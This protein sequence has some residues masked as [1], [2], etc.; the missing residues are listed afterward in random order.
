MDEQSY[1]GT[2]QTPQPASYRPPPM[3]PLSNAR[4]LSASSRRLAQ[5]SLW[6]N[7]SSSSL[8]S[9]SLGTSGSSSFRGL[10]E[11][12]LVPSLDPPSP[13]SRPSG[14]LT[15]DVSRSRARA[16]S[17]Y[18]ANS[19]QPPIAEVRVENDDDTFFECFDDDD[20]DRS[21]LQRTKRS[22]R[23]PTPQRMDAASV[24]PSVASSL[25]DESPSANATAGGTPSS[26]QL[27]RLQE[28]AL[29]AILRLKEELVKS[30]NRNTHLLQEKE[31]IA[32]DWQRKQSQW[33]MERKQLHDSLETAKASVDS[34][35]QS[36]QQEQQKDFD[37]QLRRERKESMHRKLASDN[38]IKEIQHTLA[39]TTKKLEEVTQREAQ[40]E[41]AFAMVT[42]D[43]AQV[44]QSN[45]QLEHQLEVL[46][47][48]HKNDDTVTR[49][50]QE[51]EERDQTIMNLTSSIAQNN[52]SHQEQVAQK[53]VE[54]QKWRQQYKDECEQHKADIDRFESLKSSRSPETQKMTPRNGGV[55]RFQD[56]EPLE[57]SIADRLARMRDSAERA[58]LI[59]IHKREIARLKLDHDETIQK[60]VHGHQEAIRKAQ[61]H[62]D[63][64][65]AER[66]EELKKSL[67]EEYE[68]QVQ[69]TEERQR[70]KFA[71]VRWIIIPIFMCDTLFFIL[72]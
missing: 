12:S 17:R 29:Q 42:R 13:I 8:F 41:E 52:E 70:E 27:S 48:E 54:I 4:S 5:E 49:L 71:Q 51:L 60:L 37:V 58:H 30:N 65:L 11:E 26:L 9:Y 66:L 69:E 38:R 43:K 67:K 57:S 36:A 31:Q 32:D 3:H 21:L 59:K 56:A 10:L 14:S 15:R 46:M 35:L 24:S 22:L 18:L 64:V 19:R 63:T 44:E 34:Q 33:E 39:V 16:S 68:E 53:E 28:D 23:V 62:A 45:Q 2:E 1:D 72:Y 50:Q 47:E 55:V 7:P 20:D 6:N 61:K 25:Y 40:L